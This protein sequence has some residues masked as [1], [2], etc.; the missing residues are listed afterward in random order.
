MFNT[1]AGV[2]FQLIK[3]NQSGTQGNILQ[4]H[5]MSLPNQNLSAYLANGTEQNQ[6]QPRMAY[7]K[8]CYL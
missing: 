2:T 8:K 7:E 6:K 4:F 5:F 3:D 1:L